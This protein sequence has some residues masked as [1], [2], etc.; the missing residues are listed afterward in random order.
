MRRV[1]S[2]ERYSPIAAEPRA[3]AT[4]RLRGDLHFACAIGAGTL[5]RGNPSEEYER[6]RDGES[7]GRYAPIGSCSSGLG[8]R[9]PQV[10]FWAFRSPLRSSIADACGEPHGQCSGGKSIRIQFVIQIE[11]VQ[12]TGRF[13]PLWQSHCLAVTHN[14]LRFK[15]ESV[16][17][18][19]EE[20]PNVTNVVQ[21]MCFV[22]GNQP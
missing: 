22:V 10:P 13:N 20:V 11:A 15:G 12:S 17:L 9:F 4:E 18:V 6:K 1:G 19:G 8:I 3:I 5:Q 7:S 2:G 16:L 14:F 21:V